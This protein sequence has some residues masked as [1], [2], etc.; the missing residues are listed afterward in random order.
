MKTED[1]LKELENEQSADEPSQQMDITQL[2]GALILIQDHL[3]NQQKIILD[4]SRSINGISDSASVAHR[5]LNNKIDGLPNKIND[6]YSKAVCAL[7]K[8]TQDKLDND[9]RITGAI[10]SAK[11]KLNEAQAE[12]K[13]ATNKGYTAADKGENI[14]L[15]TDELA[16][17]ITID[18]FLHYTFLLLFAFWLAYA[19]F[20]NWG[21]VFMMVSTISIILGSIFS[22]FF[23]K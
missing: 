16:K 9:N 18:R 6:T 17:K 7:T 20:K 3:A 4:L 10:I 1:L 21:T 8:A 19:R 14:L 11:D 12:L 15:T 23:P 5:D 22:R 13:S 2:Q